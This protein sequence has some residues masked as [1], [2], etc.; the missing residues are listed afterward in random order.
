MP[1]LFNGWASI[2]GCPIVLL[3]QKRRR[4]ESE[5]AKS[6]AQSRRTAKKNGNIFVVRINSSE[7]SL[8]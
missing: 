2:A 4:W 1:G 5:A 7:A 3:V 8:S 6:A